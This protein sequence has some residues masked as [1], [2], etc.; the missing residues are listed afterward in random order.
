M[1][2]SRQSI[3]QLRLVPQSLC[4]ASTCA[5]HVSTCMET[6]GGGLAQEPQWEVMHKRKS[7]ARAVL[8]L[9]L[10]SGM[11]WGALLVWCKL[12]C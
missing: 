7:P 2:I 8:R 11:N 10:A 9:H 12:E 3:L 1:V 4:L 6:D 5:F